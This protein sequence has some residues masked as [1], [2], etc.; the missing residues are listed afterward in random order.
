MEFL[1]HSGALSAAERAAMF[2]QRRVSRVID[3]RMRSSDP[4]ER[5][6]TVFIVSGIL[7]VMLATAVLSLF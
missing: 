3:S 4:D 7:L 1:S 5:D 2:N 6:E